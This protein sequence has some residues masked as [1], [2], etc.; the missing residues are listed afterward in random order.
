MQKKNKLREFQF[1]YIHRIVITNSFRYGI[2]A[3]VVSQIP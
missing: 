1:K 2:N 3:T